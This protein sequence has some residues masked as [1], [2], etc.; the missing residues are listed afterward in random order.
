L[1]ALT[2]CPCTG[3]PAPGNSRRLL[4]VA[5]VAPVTQSRARRSGAQCRASTDALGERA[6]LVSLAHGGADFH[7]ERAHGFSYLI[8]LT[9]GGQARTT[10]RRRR[11]S[12]SLP[13]TG[14]MQI[15]CT[16]AACGAHPEC[17]AN[18]NRSDL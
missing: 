18:L 10:G 9:T 2:T 11:T 1:R 6:E 7:T 14:R 3:R 8:L 5:M 16:D 4:V 17:S 12:V 15:R 13:R